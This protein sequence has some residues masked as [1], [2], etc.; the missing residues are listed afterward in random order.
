M[1][2]V[3]SGVHPENLLAK[4][5]KSRMDKQKYVEMLGLFGMGILLIF[6]ALFVDP[7]GSSPDTGLIDLGSAGAK[8]LFLILG[9]GFVGCGLGVLIKARGSSSSHRK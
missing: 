7:M 3:V 5:M 8:R 9:L 1:L 4:K 2:G 6:I